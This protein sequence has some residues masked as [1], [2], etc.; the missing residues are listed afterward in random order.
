MLT[1]SMTSPVLDDK[2]TTDLVLCKNTSQVSDSKKRK[3]FNCEI[4]IFISLVVRESVH[5]IT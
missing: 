2:S 5:Q 4:R 3:H 1:S